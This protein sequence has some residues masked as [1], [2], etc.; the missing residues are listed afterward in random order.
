MATIWFVISP[1]R[2][3]LSRVP[4]TL[5]VDVVESPNTEKGYGDTGDQPKGQEGKAENDW[6]DP[7]DNGYHPYDPYE[8]N[9]G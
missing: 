9:Q 7:I 1:T 8:W 4:V 5:R 2:L 3:S 6:S